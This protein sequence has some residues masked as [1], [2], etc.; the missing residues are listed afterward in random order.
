MTGSGEQTPE[1]TELQNGSSQESTSLAENIVSGVGAGIYE[2][3]V[4]RLILICLLM[5]VF[6]DI[7]HMPK[8][9]SIVLS[10]LVSAVLFSTHHYWFILNGEMQKGDV[11]RFTTFAFRLLA[12]IYFAVVFAI[13]GFGISAGTHAFYDIMA[14]ILN[15]CFFTSSE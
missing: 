13:R 8:T 15:A 6:Q 9:T 14:A 5:L 11:F 10:V 12:G 3:L 7:C 2:E 4:F 1:V